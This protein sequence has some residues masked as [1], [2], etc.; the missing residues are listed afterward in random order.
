MQP[1]TLT[2]QPDAAVGKDATIWYIQSQTTSKGATNTT[3]FG[4]DA[5][6]PAMEWTFDGY[7]GTKNGLIEF[8]L[9][10]IPAT[11]TVT[12]ATL[13]LFSCDSCADPGHDVIDQSSDP[14]G[15]NQ[16]LVQRITYLG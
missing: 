10:S 16:G 2:L 3:N 5:E 8:D 12:S 13:S 6:F 7:Y 15:T 9:S 11:V 1:Q 14:N 4:T